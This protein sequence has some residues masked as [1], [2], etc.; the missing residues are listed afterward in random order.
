MLVHTALGARFQRL[1]D[2]CAPLGIGGAAPQRLAGAVVH[3]H[4]GTSHGLGA[5][6]AGHPG[7][8]AF[9]PMLEVHT[10]VGDQHAGAHVHRC[11]GGQQRLAQTARFDLDHVV[12]R[13]GQR[14]ADHFERARV[15]ALQRW[16]IQP[17]GAG[18]AG[19][20]RHLAGADRAI[21]LPAARFAAAIVVFHPL[22]PLGGRPTGLL[23]GDLGLV[24]AVHLAQ[25]GQHVGGVGQAL[26]AHL[27]GGGGGLQVAL[28]MAQGHR[29]QS[30]R[31]TLDHAKWCGSKLGQRRRA[32]GGHLAWVAGGIGQG[33]AGHVLEA[34]GQFRLVAGVLG[35]GH[36]K[37]DLRDLDLLVVLVEHRR[38][39]IAP[40]RWLEPHL[41]RQCLGHRGREA[42][43]HRPDRQT[44]RIG[45]LTLAAE[46]GHKGA[47]HL[48]AKVLRALGQH[49][50]VGRGGNAR[51]PHQAHAGFMGK[52]AAAGHHQHAGL[53]LGEATGLEHR[54][55]LGAGDHPDRQTLAD[56]L[57]L[58]P[59][60][61]GQA[62]LGHRAGE[63]EQKVLVFLDLFVVAGLNRIDRRGAGGKAE[64]GVAGQRTLLGL[65]AGLEGHAALQTGRQLLAEVEQPGSGIRPAATAGR[66]ATLAG[67]GHRVGL[68]ECAE[69]HHALVEADHQLLHTGHLALR[70]DGGDVG[71]L[72]RRC[73][74][75][76]GC[77][78]P[79]GPR[80]PCHPTPLSTHASSPWGRRRKSRQARRLQ[81]Q[82]RGGVD[83]PE[84]FSRRRLQAATFRPT[85]S[86]PG[87]GR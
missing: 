34:G 69:G 40:G 75:E 58:A 24:E 19:Q 59:Q 33:A 14:D 28:Y 5:V 41:L 35:Q 7:Q 10:Q 47:P 26:D 70:A 1:L 71:S 6:E 62:G 45:P 56:A 86:A 74:P 51:A 13:L 79:G 48:P 77:Q 81:R 67:H 43:R 22:L 30:R 11:L 73:H 25:P 55:A 84:K 46:L 2:Q 39:A 8:A 63:G 4:F 61:A 12:P 16:Q 32:A 53:D 87:A 3:R 60:L 80:C 27:A 66:C 37:V 68:L 20:Q 57:H 29:Y 18:I 52:G 21:D 44:G 64:V 15:A 23:G 82:G 76:R 72:R 42:H 36:R 49:L 31:F 9:A 85:Q 17:L 38:Q 65:P 83:G 50:G 78:T 54:V